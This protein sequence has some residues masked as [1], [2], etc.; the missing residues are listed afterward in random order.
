M[1]AAVAFLLL[2]AAGCGVEDV[3]DRSAAAVAV[4]AEGCGTP[5]RGVGVVTD[6]DAVLTNAHVVAGADAV[7]VNGRPGTVVGFDGNRDLALVRV[8]GL[9]GRPLDLGAA[10][11]GDTGTLVAIDGEQ[12]TVRVPY[13]IERRIRA[14]G[15]DIHRAHGADRQAL[16]VAV[17]LEPGWSG[18]G[19]F[20]DAGRLVGIA[21]AESTTAPG[22]A[23]AVTAGEIDAFVSETGPTAMDLGP[24]L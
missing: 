6:R 19:L 23:Y 1:R 18:A 7:A 2:V 14:T 24:C 20:D 15:D 13:E 3:V 22:V 10:D 21:F 8:P 12:A 17:A 5:S 4:V 16:E 9:G 11:G